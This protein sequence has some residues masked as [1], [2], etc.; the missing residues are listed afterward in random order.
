[1]MS[2]L[3]RQFNLTGIT[4]PGYRFGQSGVRDLISR[5]ITISFPIPGNFI[6]CGGSRVAAFEK[7]CRRHACL[8]RFTFGKLVG[9][10][11]CRRRFEQN[12]VAGID[13][14]GIL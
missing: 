10:F 11:L 4:D 2:L 9:R 1:M 5:R 3:R 6:F 7:F 14:A 12:A 13:D 8:Y